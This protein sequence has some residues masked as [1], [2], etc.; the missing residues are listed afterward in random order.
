MFIIMKAV[1]LPKN[2]LEARNIYKNKKNYVTCMKSTGA[3]HHIP[4]TV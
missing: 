1:T 3:C 4:T 2:L